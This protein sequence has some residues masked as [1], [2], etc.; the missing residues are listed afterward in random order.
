MLHDI[1]DGSSTGSSMS[2]SHHQIIYRLDGIKPVEVTDRQHLDIEQ[3]RDFVQR[4]QIIKIG[5][6]GAA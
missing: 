6:I 3:A 2:S 4:Q 1:G 5:S